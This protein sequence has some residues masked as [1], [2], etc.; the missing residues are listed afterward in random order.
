ML[1]VGAALK[2]IIVFLIGRLRY[3]IDIYIYFLQSDPPEALVFYLGLWLLAVLRAA[4]RHRGGARPAPPFNTAVKLDSKG[5]FPPKIEFSGFSRSI[6]LKAKS[7][8]QSTLFEYGRSYHP[9]GIARAHLDGG[10]AA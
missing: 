2:A 7:V 4:P 1:G 5:L 6:L 3:E 10:D 9:W 8:G